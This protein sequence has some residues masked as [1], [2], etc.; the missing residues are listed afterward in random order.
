MATVNIQSPIKVRQG[1]ANKATTEMLEQ[2]QSFQPGYAPVTLPWR[3]LSVFDDTRR[4]NNLR[5][6]PTS[7]TQNLELD[8]R[9]NETDAASQVRL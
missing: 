9:E 4:I 1:G 8:T 7:F 2:R 6:P 3:H 5:E